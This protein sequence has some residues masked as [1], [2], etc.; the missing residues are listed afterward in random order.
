M[1]NIEKDGIL[2]SDD[3]EKEEIL[4]DTFFKGSH[5]VGRTFDQQFDSEVNRTYE[6][7]VKGLPLADAIDDHALLNE[8]ISMQ[9]ALVS[10][11]AD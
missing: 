6:E 3:K 10:F 4:F 5:M 1:G 11:I 9:E 8:E 2:Y 7:I